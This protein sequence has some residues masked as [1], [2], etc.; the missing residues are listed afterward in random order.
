MKRLLALAVLLSLSLVLTG[1]CTRQK[2]DEFSRFEGTANQPS[3]WCSI[4]IFSGFGTVEEPERWT[5]AYSP[6]SVSEYGELLCGHKEQEE[7]ASCVNQIWAHYRETQ[8]RDPEPGESTS[9]PFAV[10]I[11]NQLFLGSYWSDPF[12]AS[13]QIT[14]KRS[15]QVCRGSYSALRGDTRAVFDVDCDNGKHGKADIVLDRTGRNGIGR[16][17]M[18]DGTRGDIVFGHANLDSA[19]RVVGS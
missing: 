9:G 13:F 6:V 7:Y 19:L 14:G 8:R 2:M 10:M 3:E 15:G 5:A 4:S 12:S 16:M 17:Y 1:C 18:D 11:W